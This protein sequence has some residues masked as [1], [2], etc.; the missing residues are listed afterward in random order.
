M[1]RSV[2]RPRVK[3]CCA[4]TEALEDR[5]LLA[6]NPP[7]LGINIRRL[8]FDAGDQLFADAMKDPNAWSNDLANP[9]DTTSLTP[10]DARGWPKT[11]SGIQIIHSLNDDVAGTYAL[12]FTGQATVSPV[13]AEPGVMVQNAVYDPL[14]NATTAQV[15]VPP[16]LH[17]L[18]LDFTNTLRLPT[19]LSATGITDVSLMRPISVG[20]STSYS[21]STIFTAPIL[22]LLSH[23]S[24]LRFM[25]YSLTNNNWQV[26]WSDRTVPDQ[27]QTDGRGGAWEYAVAL[28]NQAG[29]DMWINIP[30]RA[31]DDYVTRLAQLIT[32]GSDGVNPYT[33]PQGSAVSGSNPS[34]VP[35]GGPVWAGLKPGLHV[36]VEYSNE[37]WNSSFGQYGQNLQAAIAE[38]NAGGSAL[39]YDNVDSE[40]VWAIRRQVERTVQISNLFRAVVG[41]AAMMA[42]IRPVYEWQ[43]GNINNTAS[44]AM[45][46]LNDYY[47]NADGYHHVA[48]PHAPSY[49][50]WGAGGGAYGG[51]GNSSGSGDVIV[52]DNN[53]ATPAV[54]GY[55]TDPSGA[56]WGFSGSAGIAANGSALGN[57][58]STS[59]SQAAWVQG[60]GQLSQTINF[61]GGL[62]DVSFDAASTGSEGIQVL[63][64]GKDVSVYGQDA[65]YV[66][67][68]TSTYSRLYTIAFDTGASAG[69]H[70]VTFVGVG[71]T[72]AAFISNVAV[73]TANAMYASG[74]ANI[75]S[76][77]Q[78]EAAWSRAFGLH[79]TSYEGGFDFG[80][81]WVG[82]PLQI[83]A[84]QDPRAQQATFAQL[85]EF[86]AAGG[87]LL[88]YYDTTN[89]IW[90][91]TLNIRNL[92]TP[93]LAAIDSAEH[94]PQTPLTAGT[95]LPTTAGQSV[96]VSN[97]AGAYSGIAGMYVLNAPAAGTYHLAL[98]GSA[99]GAPMGQLFLDGTRVKGA[100]TLPPGVANA[101]SAPL[102]FTLGAGG[103]HTLLL[104]SRGSGTLGAGSVVVTAGA[105]SALPATL[106]APAGL[107]AVAASLSQVNL[108]W[109]AVAGAA[110]FRIERSS[111]GGVYA[112]LGS[113]SGTTYSDTLAAP[114]TTY[115]YRV[116]AFNAAGLGAPSNG[117]KATTPA[118]IVPSPWIDQDIGSPAAPGYANFAGGVVT[119]AGGG[120]DIYNHFDNFNYLSQTLGGDGS[121]VAEVNSIS[122]TSASAKAGVM[123]RASSDPTDMFIDVMV[124][125]GGGVTMQWRAAA[126]TNVTGVSASGSIKAPRWVRLTRSG[127]T[128]SGAY[129]ADGVNWTA[130]GSPQALALPTASLVGLAVTAHQ[131]ASRCVSVFSN[132]AVT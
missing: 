26:N 61:S 126:D 73:E 49:Y 15:I 105:G 79:E 120:S 69:P 63:L 53:F 129:S 46:F 58:P 106:A 25:D 97:S 12:S 124:Q 96:T 3:G 7:Q 111:S 85:N 87:G 11:D 41:S 94:S 33:G 77:I 1:R 83:A 9:G 40:P 45:N 82:T 117:R 24:A 18:E 8:G 86:Y 62:A 50:L 116:I 115:A 43:Y 47:N 72:G 102:T 95:I 51:V 31:S 22:Q 42:A 28:A 112:L 131:S 65:S 114:G 59:A 113:S 19:D 75:S 20:S 71:G 10:V 88:M 6:A 57:P 44:A 66:W 74:V 90:S 27:V 92:N 52:P 21:P 38:V 119:V 64:D 4:H 84:N 130:I 55:A 2:R 16:G 122:L 78:S 101:T 118:A 76:T 60:N 39:N 98:S 91:I 67:Q 104:L 80:S 103:L 125:A 23:F 81:G 121:I 54:S 37:V 34:P 36:Y 68:I 93:K 56:A 123:F 17:D 109:S 32:Y 89:H 5:L 100:V 30:A 128:F 107:S 132:V 108:S 13:A 48:N 35:A 14:A 29:K 127:S 99:T 70:T 110:G